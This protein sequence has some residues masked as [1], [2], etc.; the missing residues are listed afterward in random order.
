[1]VVVQENVVNLERLGSGCW[2]VSWRKRR[3]KV[4]VGSNASRQWW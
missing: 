1:M 2:V 3:P 4:F